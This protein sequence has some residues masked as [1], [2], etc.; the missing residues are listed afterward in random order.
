L[1]VVVVVV[2]YCEIK[3]AVEP[4]RAP[5]ADVR[6]ATANGDVVRLGNV[7][8]HCLAIPGKGGLEDASSTGTEFC[9]NKF[10]L[11]KDE[12]PLALPGI[13]CEQFTGVH[14]PLAPLD[15]EVERGRRSGVRDDVATLGAMK[16][17]VQDGVATLGA[18]RELPV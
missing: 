14:D 2:T 1:V 8:E 18:L 9:G 4:L 11:G 13:V 3:Q 17:C 10:P 6:P 7:P 15:L 16:E 12:E 5:K